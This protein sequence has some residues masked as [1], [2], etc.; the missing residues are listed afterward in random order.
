MNR[1]TK[2]YVICKVCFP[3]MREVLHKKFPIERRA[4]LHAETAKL[5]SGGKKVYY[6]NSKVEGNILK[7]HLI[8]SE[9]NVIQEIESKTQ[10]TKLDYKNTK[11]MNT[12][13]LTILFVKDICS[14][15]FDR[16]NRNI[17]EGNL[18]MLVGN[19]WMKINYYVDK[20]WKIYI[21]KIKTN[22][23][24]KDLQY[25]IPIKDIFKNVILQNNC[26]EITIA[27]YS[28]FLLNKSKKQIVFHSDI[29]KEI[30]NLNTALTFLRMIANYEKYI[31]N[32]GYTQLPL[33][34]K[35][36][37]VR[38]EKKY[39]VNLEQSHLLYHNDF[40]SFRTKRYLSCY[41]LLN[42]TDKLISD[43]KDLNRPF[44]I[45]MRVALSLFLGNVQINLTKEKSELINE[46]DEYKLI[47]G[48]IIYS[49]YIYTPKHVKSPLQ[50]VVEEL[51]KKEREEE[52]LLR[53]RF[54]GKFSLFPI[55]LLKRER[56]VF[57]TGIIQSK[58]NQSIIMFKSD[59]LSK[60][61]IDEIEDN[62]LHAK[63]T[64]FN[65]RK[66]GKSK[67]I[68]DRTEEV[69]KE[70]SNKVKSQ[71][72][73]K[74]Y[75][76]NYSSESK[77]SSSDESENESD[78]SEEKSEDNFKFNQSESSI[79]SNEKEKENNNEVEKNKKEKLSKNINNIKIYS[80]NKNENENINN[81]KENNEKDNENENEETSIN[82]KSNDNQNKIL[83]NNNK[84]NY[85]NDNKNDIIN[86]KNFNINNNNNI[87][88][89]NTKNNYNINN[90]INNNININLINNH[91]LNPTLNYSFNNQKLL[92]N[93]C[94]PKYNI[95]IN[96]LRMSQR[97]EN[98]LHITLKQK[99]NPKKSYS[100]EVKSVKEKYRNSSNE[101]LNS[102]RKLTFDVSE[103]ESF[104]S[105]KESDNNIDNVY[106]VTSPQMNNSKKKNYK[107]MSEITPTKEDL[108]SKAI[109]AFLGDENTEMSTPNKDGDYRKNGLN[110]SKRCNKYMGNVIKTDIT[111]NNEEP[112]GESKNINKPKKKIKRS[113]ILTTMKVQ[114]KNKSKHVTFIQEKENNN[115]PKPEETF[116]KCHSFTEK[117][118]IDKDNNDKDN[119]ILNK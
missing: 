63:S 83:E 73:L 111:N 75:D 114:I 66:G 35:G 55:S 15:I 84:D 68:V 93:Y 74:Y 11:I 108:F 110:S 4:I 118:E 10:D 2:K 30:F 52:E 102:N 48:K 112:K 97:L 43:S 28:T 105:D 90:Y 57:G 24:E 103:E 36:W 41:G 77:N 12:N 92:N 7:R 1:R 65:G 58:R 79:D 53:M 91:Y 37:Y 95:N 40:R 51:K 70:I 119:R 45:I 25:I 20:V 33:Y 59:V 100:A 82:D 67:T 89:I 78:E 71:M 8:Y 94:E 16:N 101:Y 6:F 49:I 106:L 3:L 88:N 115:Q 29:W 34:K 113:S 32:F 18:E 26:L 42:Q 31:Y 107:A 5:L 116:H 98:E 44:N 109:I 85:T 21:N 62:R 69:S 13:N 86:I 50:K 23:N 60:N 38:K 54:K 27:E 17:L 61:K 87:T 104:I 39:Y 81:N 80:P 72:A 19:K 47:K 9:I 56:R 99:I 76:I 46:Y 14:R 96:S 22:K 117:N 64:K